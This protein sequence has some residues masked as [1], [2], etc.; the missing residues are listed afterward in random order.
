LNDD[1]EASSGPRKD[2]IAREHIIIRFAY[3]E[4]VLAT[5]IAVKAES[6]SGRICTLEEQYH[7]FARKPT[8][9]T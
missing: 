1:A 4:R 9:A 7:A 6:G 5:R 8:S 3:V 2:E